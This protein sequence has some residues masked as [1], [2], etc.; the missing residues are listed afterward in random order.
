MAKHFPISSQLETPSFSATLSLALIPALILGACESEPP[1]GH[2]FA[3]R[4][5]A[6]V[7]IAENVGEPP[8]EENQWRIGTEPVL[9]I[10]TLEGEDAYMFQRIWGA[11]RLSDGRI[12]VADNRA[13]EIRIYSP[14]GEH[15][16]TFGRRGEGPAEF[17]SPVLMGS[18]P[19]DTLV[20]VDRL[21]RRVNLYDPD[22]GFIRGA[23]AT[24]E[25][26][27]YLLTVG[28]FQSGAVMIWD[29]E[30]T[31][32]MP[33]GF[34]RFPIRYLSVELDGSI[35]HDFGVHLGTETVYS[36]R[37]EGE[38]TMVL[39]T[40]LPFG[41]GPSA[42]VARDRFFYS[43]QDSYEIQVTDE[44]GRLLRIIRRDLA[45]RPVTEAHRAELTQGMEDQADDNDQVR[46]FR[47]MMRDAP[48][49]DY[50][51]ALGPI[52]ADALG[53]LWVEETRMPDEEIRYT[54]IFDPEGRMVGQVVLPAR[55]QVQEIGADYL[56]G[57][58]ADDLGVS[59]LRMYPLERPVG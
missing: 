7:I 1:S 33:N 19:G 49:P 36:S 39:S 32:E 24:S 46:E 38:G 35:G 16:S 31:Q 34:F 52:Y 41:K 18:L 8:V 10:G 20:V 2:T 5:S 43:S 28:M 30:W 17:D 11:T 44:A 27:G 48:V 50:H 53:Y 22:E 9:Q 55:V 13:S 4:D 47:R 45:P 12:A 6:G 40:S 14:T 25:I 37:A 59:Y 54:T 3:T 57:R 15:L 23:T 58:W 51:P 42:A 21:L 26:Q 56:L 29:S